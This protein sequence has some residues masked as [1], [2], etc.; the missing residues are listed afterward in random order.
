MKTKK[1]GEWYEIKINQE[2]DGLSID[3]I[4][5]QVWQAP[6]KQVHS[7]RMEKGVK[8]NGEDRSWNLPLQA[9][10][11]LQ[12]KLFTEEPF[13]VVPTYQDVDVLYEDDHLI[14]FNKPADMD[15]HPNDPDQTDTLAN[16]AAYYL[17]SNGEQRRIKHVHRLDRDTT[18]AVLFAKHALAGSIL[19]RLLEERKI[20]RTY[21]ALVH[22]KLKRK[23]G[24][25]QQPIGRDRHHPT[26]RRV[27]PTGQSAITHYEILE[28]D[29]KQDQ[30]FIQCQ[31]DTGRTH[32]IRVHLGHIGHP[33]VG[34]SLYGG[35]P[36]FYRQ[37]LHAAKLE[38]PHPF[39][40][41]TIRVD[42]PSE[43]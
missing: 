19:D 17:L 14:I 36:I 24:T 12:L 8:V 43:F 41:E 15:T 38:L 20:K 42:C 6:K 33:I 35:K 2:W 10:D 9:G 13:G 21:H 28:Y 34:D 30:S 32:Q 29:A 25:I 5:R 18:G 26:R 4:F 1:M 22:G 16:G 27:S 40:N 11:R 39:T 7:L 37:A 23:K 3:S 31:L